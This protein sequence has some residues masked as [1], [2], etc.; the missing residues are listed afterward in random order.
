MF[1]FPSYSVLS[2]SIFCSKAAHLKMYCSLPG[3]KLPWWYTK[4][5][6]SDNLRDICL[7]EGDASHGS[8]RLCLDLG[9]RKFEPSK[10]FPLELAQETL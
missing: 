2:L 8:P 4:D 10:C 1:Y 7:E 9:L 3:L 6:C 5:G